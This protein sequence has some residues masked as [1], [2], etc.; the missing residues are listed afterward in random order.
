MNWDAVRDEVTRLVQDLLRFDTTNPPGNE[1]PA[2]EFLAGLLQSEGFEPTVIESAPGR[3]NVI[4][5]LPGDG[6]EAPLLLMGHLD[7][8]P[9]EASKWSV[10]PFRVTWSTAWFGAVAPPI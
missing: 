10:L 1:L 4:A 6:T 2:A 7:V 9:A 8:V 3:G 5:R